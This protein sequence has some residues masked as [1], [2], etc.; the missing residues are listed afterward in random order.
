MYGAG[1]A[2][3]SRDLRNRLSSALPQI[4]YLTR[5]GISQPASDPCGHISFLSLSSSIRYLHCKFSVSEDV[6]TRK[7]TSSQKPLDI[8]TGENNSYHNK[9]IISNTQFQHFTIFTQ[10]PIRKVFSKVQPSSQDLFC[11]L[12]SYVKKPLQSHTVCNATPVSV[13]L[14]SPNNFSEDV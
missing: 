1:S 3:S 8:T 4:S 13:C 6:K 12:V 9:K 10:L 14:S 2:T 11:S 5:E 7:P